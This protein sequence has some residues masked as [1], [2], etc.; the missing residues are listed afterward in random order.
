MFTGSE[1]DYFNFTKNKL[2]LSKNPI[3][4]F[5]FFSNTVYDLIFLFLP[6]VHCGVKPSCG[7]FPTKRLH[8]PGC[9]QLQVV[10]SQIKMVSRHLMNY[11]PILAHLS[12]YSCLHLGSINF[13]PW[14]FPETFSIVIYPFRRGTLPPFQKIL[15][16]LPLWNWDSSLKDYPQSLQGPSKSIPLGCRCLPT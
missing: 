1:I 12:R 13:L 6:S 10:T 2:I 4:Y 5:E 7:N 16:Q 8:M 15:G 9:S 11:V 14:I 3:T